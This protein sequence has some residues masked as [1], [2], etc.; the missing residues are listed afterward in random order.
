MESEYPENTDLV[1]TFP[2][3]FKGLSQAPVLLK[4]GGGVLGCLD[5]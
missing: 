1:K 5:Q 3:P 2:I 4:K